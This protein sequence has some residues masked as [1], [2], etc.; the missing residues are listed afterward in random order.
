MKIKIKLT[1]GIGLLFG[2]IALLTVIGGLYVHHLSGDTR[3]ILTDNYNTLDY[4]RNMLNAL[5]NG[6]ANPNQRAEFEKNLSKQRN[7]VTEAGEYDLTE[8]LS[9]DFQSLRGQ[10]DDP[11]LLH[12]VHADITNIMLLNM[13]AIR[14]KSAVAEEAADQAILWI[15]II[16]SICFLIAF[17]LLVNLPG[18]IANPIRELT[19]SIKEIAAMHYERRVH[20]ESHS[21]FGE[22]AS[23]F[24]SMAQKLEEYQMSNV[25]KLMME[26]KRIE[27]LINNIRDPV[28]GLDEH[29]RILFMNDIALQITGLKEEEIRGKAVQDIALHNDLMRSLVR[30]LAGSPESGP[31]MEAPVLKIYAGKKESYFE[32]EVIPIRFVPTG[33]KEE[34]QVGTVILLR[35]VTPYKELDSAKTNF[36]ASVSHELKTPLSSIQMGV[37]LLRN[38]KTGLLNAEQE[39]LLEN[40]DD[41][42]ER[43]LRTTTEL[44]NI[45][46]VESG[47]V[48]LSL[49]ASDPAE[50]LQYAV[51]ANKA[52]ADLKEIR[53]ETHI[54]PGLPRVLADSE[55]AAWVMTNLISNAIRYSYENSTVYLG[56]FREDGMVCFSVRD[57]GQG[58]APEYIDR[59]FER[60]FRIPGTRKEG[61]G[62][63]LAISKEFVEAQKGRITVESEYGAGSTFTMQL[64]AAV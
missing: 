64:P 50:I 39:G 60:Y 21:E 31:K 57:T 25:E 22:L 13:Q 44:L 15:G 12:S 43:L 42:V 26:K 59:I 23:A 7:N 54:I 19:L 3:N 47:I 45:T 52:A 16:G 53:F 14:R 41:D 18:N 10:P 33:E 5:N 1:L 62:L 63:G 49:V 8:K 56:I 37:Q 58:I 38:K 9:K 27:T 35:N 28:I 20:F 36:I 32:K 6:I 17:V 11:V 30:E 46:Q 4:A 40:M 34:K 2:M 55:K 61:T 29:M 48:K 24:N 51:Q